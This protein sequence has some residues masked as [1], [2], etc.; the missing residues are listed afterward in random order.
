MMAATFNGYLS[1]TIISCYSPTNVSDEKD[2]IVFYDELSSLVRC[3]SKHNVLIVG[4]D[5]KA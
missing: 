1:T 3:I 2:L 4:G 5:M